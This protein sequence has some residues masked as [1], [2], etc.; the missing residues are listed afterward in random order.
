MLFSM[1]YDKLFNST[2][3]YY[4]IPE[5][6]Q[7]VDGLSLEKPSTTD[8]K[9]KEK[10][11]KILKQLS[12]VIIKDSHNDLRYRNDFDQWVDQALLEISM[13]K[14]GRKLFKRLLKSPFP[15][16]IRLEEG[17]MD[18]RFEKK[19]DWNTLQLTQE[20]GSATI[21]IPRN[22]MTETSLG[23]DF[24]QKNNLVWTNPDNYP[25]AVELAHEL[26]HVMHCIEDEAAQISRTADKTGLFHPHFD[27]KEEQLTICG[28][29]TKDGKID[30]C[31][32]AF[33]QAYG[34]NFRS[35]HHGFPSKKQ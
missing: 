3:S 2:P 27:D 13:T 30:I 12:D 35:S 28:L 15:I 7:K 32:N 1:L 17:K 25:V 34:Y 23:L 22:H 19:M 33:V 24:Y 10:S 11:E 5:Y 18:V 31:E 8:E 14:P 6:K 16:F 21:C 20:I 9:I 26:I 29:A 4:D